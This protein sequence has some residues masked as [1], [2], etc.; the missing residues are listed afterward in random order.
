M[1]VP[2]TSQLR[3]HIMF[4]INLLYIVKWV[5]RRTVRVRN[6]E[7]MSKFVKV[8]QRNTVDLFLQTQC[9]TNTVITNKV[10]H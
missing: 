3:Q 7:T 6:Y 4:G 2:M 9:T 5:L 8:M 10:N 1:I